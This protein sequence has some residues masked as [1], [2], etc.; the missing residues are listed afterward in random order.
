MRKLGMA[1]TMGLLAPIVGCGSNPAPPTSMCVG[2]WVVP[3]EPPVYADSLVVDAPKVLW[4]LRFPGSPTYEGGGPVLAGEKL[5]LTTAARV[6]LISKDGSS[7]KDVTDTL[8]GISGAD[9]PWS[10]PTA[11][12]DGNLYVVGQPG[13]GSLTSAGQLRWVKSFAEKNPVEYGEG[14]IHVPSYFPAILSPAGV[15][16]A[17]ASDERLH[18]LRSR[19]GQ[20]LWSTP[21]P[22]PASNDRSYVVGGGGSHVMLYKAGVGQYIVDATTGTGVGPM[23]LWC[24]G[25]DVGGYGFTIA[26]QC[27][28]DDLTYASCP[29]PTHPNG[30]PRVERAYHGYLTAPGERLVMYDFALDN[31]GYETDPRT[32]TLYDRGGSIAVG[33]AVV[34][35]SPTLVGADGTIYTMVWAASGV[36]DSACALRIIAYSRDLTETWRIDVPS[37][38]LSIYGVVLDRDGVLYVSTDDFSAEAMNLYAIQ[39][40]SPGLARSS[41]PSRRH[42]NQG[43]HWMVPPPQ[44]VSYV[45][46][47]EGPVDVGLDTNPGGQ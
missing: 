16:Y 44:A 36:P 21:A 24:G 40:R 3:A 8:P 9:V 10:D 13:I 17:V 47:G 35:G 25:A 7:T 27:G 2:D 11:D 20:E 43:T 45:D 15:L 28:S 33:P 38:C 37:G 19:D 31:H 42:D 6:L 39:T 26:N 41:W 32:I 1:A 14:H 22:I 29:L 46:G 23:R 5:A 4:S 18:A 30:S 34:H 12:S